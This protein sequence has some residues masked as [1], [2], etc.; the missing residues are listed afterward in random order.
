M[1]LLQISTIVICLIV[2][3]VG[4]GCKTREIAC[5]TCNHSFIVKLPLE[6]LHTFILWFVPNVP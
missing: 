4:L 6:V 2:W 5:Y 3:F 1:F